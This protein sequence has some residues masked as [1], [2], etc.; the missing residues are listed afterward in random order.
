MSS[1]DNEFPDS[2]ND[3]SEEE[4]SISKPGKTDKVDQFKE[5]TDD[6][7][8]GSIQDLSELEEESS[9]TREALM[10]A[11]IAHFYSSK[12]DKAKQ[13]QED[14]SKQ[15]KQ[16]YVDGI[17]EF[18][19]QLSYCQHVL[20]EVLGDFLVIGHGYNGK[21]VKIEFAKTKRDRDALHNAVK[22]HIIKSFRL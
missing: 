21:S 12:T 8:I 11:L 18:E 2:D 1:S 20:S 17:K 9:K 16:T 6:I 3:M 5:V 15:F 13:L 14:V 4:A 19:Q 22:R 7:E 10:D